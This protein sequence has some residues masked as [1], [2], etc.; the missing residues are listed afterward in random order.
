MKNLDEHTF[1][2][3]AFGSIYILHNMFKQINMGLFHLSRKID[4][5]QEKLSEIK[6]VEKDEKQTQTED[7]L[8]ISESQIIENIDIDKPSEKQKKFIYF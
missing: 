1:Y 5:Y 3:F 4:S 6:E 8:E 7:L 2:L